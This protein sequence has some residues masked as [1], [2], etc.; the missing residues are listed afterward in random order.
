[1]SLSY[2]NDLITLLDRVFLGDSFFLSI[3]RISFHSLLAYRISP[4][5]SADSL[6]G[7]LL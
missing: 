3:L 7:V 1:M 4:E 2:L 6:V 5:K